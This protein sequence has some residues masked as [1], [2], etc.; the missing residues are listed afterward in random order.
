MRLNDS[1]KTLVFGNVNL[2]RYCQ[3]AGISIDKL[4]RCNIEKMGNT[5]VF[6]F[7]KENAPKSNLLIPLDVDMATQPDVVLKMEILD[8]T[9]ITF[10][11]T[12]KTLRLLAM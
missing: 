3:G 5:Y 1:S 4:K 7:S 9:N 10:E 8:D 6:V 12:D 2:I 11:T